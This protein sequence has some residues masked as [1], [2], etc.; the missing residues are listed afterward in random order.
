M[1]EDMK[2]ER[3]DMKMKLQE[4]QRQDD[5]TYT[6]VLGCPRCYAILDVRTDKWLYAADYGPPST[7][8]KEV[9]G[10]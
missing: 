2:C 3:C 5:G 6:R 8:R 10:L 9:F 7:F 1:T 4:N